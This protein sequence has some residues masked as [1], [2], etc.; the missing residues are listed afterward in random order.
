MGQYGFPSW[1]IHLALVIFFSTACGILASEWKVV[2]RGTALSVGTAMAV[3][4]VSTL[5][6]VLGNRIGTTGQA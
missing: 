1:S 4:V 5:I 3:L 2:S 6:I